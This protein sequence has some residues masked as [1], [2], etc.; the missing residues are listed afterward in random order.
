MLAYY[1]SWHLR[2]AWA[3]LIFKDECPPLAADLVAKA[4]RSGAAARKASGSKRTAA[5]HPVHSFESLIA[6]LALRTRNTIRLKGSKASFEQLTKAS[7]VQARA[8]ELVE[9]VP[10]H[11]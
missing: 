10:K 1:L 5:G 8:L 9:R 6:E 2:E 3:E 7:A 11:A 4:E